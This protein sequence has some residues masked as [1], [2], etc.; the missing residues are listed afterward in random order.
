MWPHGVGRAN[1][2]SPY[3]ALHCK[4]MR[5]TPCITHAAQLKASC[6]F[7]ATSFWFWMSTKPCSAPSHRYME[8]PPNCTMRP[9]LSMFRICQLFKQYILLPA[10]VYMACLWRHLPPSLLNILLAK[11]A[12]IKYGLK[13]RFPDSLADEEGRQAGG[14]GARTERE[15]QKCINIK[16]LETLS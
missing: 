16:N 5:L 13:G 6:K 8:G 1:T 14:M 7:C 2:K 10:K 9:T 4:T 12:C 15:E 3:L 11:N